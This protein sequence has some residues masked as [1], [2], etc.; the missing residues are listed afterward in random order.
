MNENMNMSKLNM[1]PVPTVEIPETELD[2]LKDSV[3]TLIK[4]HLDL[5]GLY[6][7]ESLLKKHHRAYL[8]VRDHADQVCREHKEKIRDLIVEFL[9]GAGAVRLEEKETA[10]GESEKEQSL[11]IAEG[12]GKAVSFGPENETG[13]ED[14][15]GD[16][17]PDK[18]PGGVIVVKCQDA[19]SLNAVIELL[20]QIS[21][22]ELA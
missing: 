16:S 8:H 1:A 6:E 20:E 18:T 19:E 2:W 11:Q 21:E 5:I 9:L 14:D 13:P 7:R 17:I 10:S 4:M 22:I 3:Q 15:E 12:E